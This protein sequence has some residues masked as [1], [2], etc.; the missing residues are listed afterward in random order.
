MRTYVTVY[1]GTMLLAMVLVPVVSRL[2]KRY[3]LVDAPGP[4]KVH[5]T[6]IPRIGGIAFALATLAFVLPILFIHNSIGLSFYASDQELITLLIAA[7]FIFAVGLADDL[8]SLAGSIKLLCLVGASLAVCASGATLQSFSVGPWFEIGTGWAAWPLTVLWIVGVTVCMNFIDGLDGLAGGIAVIVCGTIAFIAFLTGQAAMAVLMLALLG[9]V[10]GFLFFNFYPARIF[11]GDC[12]SMFLGFTIGAGSVVCQ[13]KTHTLVGLAVPLLAMGVPVLDTGFAIIRRR[14]FERRSI[15]AADRKHLHHRLLDL[16]LH[17]R[18]VVIVIYSVTAISAG[19]GVFVLTVD[20][21][22]SM[23][24]LAVGL[25]FLFALFACLNGGRYCEMLKALKRNREIGQENKQMRR[26][27]EETQN[28]M[29]NASSLDEYWEVLCRMGGRM[30]FQ[31]IGLWKQ[32]LRG[33]T[34]IHAWTAPP[35]KFPT[36]KVASVRLPVGVVGDEHWELTAQ[37]WVNGCLEIGG[38]ETAL[39]LRLIDEFPPLGF[40]LKPEVPAETPAMGAESGAVQSEE[41]RDDKL[42]YKGLGRFGQFSHA[43]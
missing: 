16:G 2:A 27:F 14:F 6:P 40:V 33:R 35:E 11:M 38:Q 23:A 30:H 37:I 15:F 1:F 17:Q 3:R 5:K 28:R 34:N 24:L 42:Q 29:R 13:M 7:S 9:S 8:C 19:L 18:T 32:S 22:W 25:L 39:L 10:T 20:S 26:I 12:G 21:G 31:A 36:R 41:Q 4:R 43:S